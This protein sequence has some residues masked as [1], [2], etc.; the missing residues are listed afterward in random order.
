[1]TSPYVYEISG[2]LLSVKFNI[3]VDNGAAGVLPEKEDKVAGINNMLHSLFGRVELSI[4]NECITQVPDGYHF[5]AYLANMMGFDSTVKSSW[6]QTV[7][8]G[9]DKP[10][11]YFDHDDGTGFLLRNLHFRKRQITDEAY[12]EEGM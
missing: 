5:K 1:M 9:D 3:Y 4:N 12:S 8:Y 2:L 10:R 11:P 6:L 7:G